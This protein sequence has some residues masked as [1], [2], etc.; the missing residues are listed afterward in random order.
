MKER[1]LDLLRTDKPV[2]EVNA[3][4]ILGCYAQTKKSIW[5]ISEKPEKNH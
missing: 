4:R 5:L 3:M 2:S 1:D